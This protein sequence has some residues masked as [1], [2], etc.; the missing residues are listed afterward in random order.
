MLGEWWTVDKTTRHSDGQELCPK[1]EAPIFI[2]AGSGSATFRSLL[3][4]YKTRDASSRQDALFCFCSCYWKF[5]IDIK[6]SQTMNGT[7]SLPSQT[8]AISGL[9]SPKLGCHQPLSKASLKA[10][11]SCHWLLPLERGNVHQK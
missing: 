5:E 3:N 10:P 2:L 4:G 1:P 7:P 8:I 9:Y 11:H 6:E